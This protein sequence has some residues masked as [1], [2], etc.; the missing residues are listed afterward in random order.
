MIHLVYTF[1]IL[2]PHDD[3]LDIG[4]IYSKNQLLGNLTIS[5]PELPESPRTTPLRYNAQ[6]GIWNGLL[7]LRREVW[8]VL[9]F[10]LYMVLDDG[11][12]ISCEGE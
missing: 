4:Q 7:G 10:S 2:V 8:M 12:I 5:L 6:R 11:D 3:V 9:E 1:P